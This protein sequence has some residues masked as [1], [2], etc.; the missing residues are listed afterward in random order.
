MGVCPGPEV[1]PPRS[2]AH[3]QCVPDPRAV[4]VC[5]AG[6]DL[7]ERERSVPRRRGRLELES[8][9]TY[10]ESRITYRVDRG[11]DRKCQTREESEMKRRE[12]TE[13]PKDVSLDDVAEA[14]K[15][16]M[17]VLDETDQHI[18]TA[19]HRLMSS[20]APVEP[21]AIAKAVG[22][23]SLERVKERLNRWPG[24]F[25]DDMGRVG[26]FRGPAIYKLEPEYRLVAAG[27]TTYA[28]S[29]LDTLFIPG[30]TGTEVCVEASDPVSGEPVALVVDRDGARDV[31]PAGALGSMVIPD[32]PVGYDVIE[33]LCHRV[34][35]FA[36][37]NAAVKRIAR[38]EV[39]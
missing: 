28:W 30:I 23:V 24:V 13:T 26:G 8:W 17:P 38:H 5:G 6:S 36:S 39:T 25:R 1:G 35:F 10:L 33:S 27:N 20:G 37:H 32:G 7:P 31:A 9:N 11:G 19:V 15:A 21:A 2:P 3:Q 22:G 4:P 29:A 12:E 34:L 16:A 18:A 14:I